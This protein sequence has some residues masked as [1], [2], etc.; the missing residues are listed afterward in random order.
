ML[1]ALLIVLPFTA[2]FSSCPL[3]FFQ[4]SSQVSSPKP[5]ITASA[6]EVPS[7]ERQ[8][9]LTEEFKDDVVVLRYQEFHDARVRPEYPLLL[10]TGMT[11]R[12]LALL[13]LRL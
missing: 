5:G 11:S 12:P 6:H 1:L 8:S 3:S 4:D 7:S 13:V 2:P 9:V 10:L